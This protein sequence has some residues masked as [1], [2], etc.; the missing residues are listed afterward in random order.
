MKKKKESAKEM[1][2]KGETEVKKLA[3]IFDVAEKT[4]RSWI[5]KGN[6]L[7]SLDELQTLDEEIKISVKRAL[8]K[9][10]KAYTK[11]PENT[12][13]QSLVSMLK[14]YYKTIE[15]SKEFMQYLKKFLDWQIDYYLSKGDETT[16]R[17]IQ[18]CILGEDDLVEYFKKRAES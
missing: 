1:F 14:Q 12:A 5:K 4:I 3:K 17:E 2:L 6:W 16:S 11:N 8:V 18:K 7:N 15:P 13:L 9:S 10:L